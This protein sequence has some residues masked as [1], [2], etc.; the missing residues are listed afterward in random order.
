MVD[1]VDVKLWGKN[2]GVL[3]WD[4]ARGVA[5]FQY[6]NEFI[7][8]GLEISPFAMP[9]N[10]TP[11]SFN[12]NKG[13]CFKG[14]PGLIADSLPDNYG[15]KIIEEWFISQAQPL[16]TITPLDQ[17]CYIGERSMGALEFSPSTQITL[18]NKSTTIDIAQIT[19]L[20]QDILNNRLQFKSKLEDNQETLLDILKI[21]TSAGGAKPKAII[22]YNPNTKEVRSGQVK[23]PQGFEYYILKFDG[24]EEEKKIR[25][26]PLGI[27]RIEYAYYLMSKDCGINMMD[28]FLIEEGQCAHFMT[29]RFDRTEDGEK[30]FVQTLAALGHLDR[31]LPHSYER[32]F[33]IMRGIN[34]SYKEMEQIYRRM[35][36]N[37]MARNH[38]DHTKNH[39]FIMTQKGNWQLAPAYDV[40]Y[41][42]SSISKWTA[43]HQMSINGKRDDFSNNDLLKVAE[44]AEIKKPKNIIEEV[45]QVVSQWNKYAKEAEVA[46]E[47]REEIGRELIPKLP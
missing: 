27:G 33:A 42:Y 21:G 40:M 47:Y 28:S 18:L 45:S 38:D 12:E 22:A 19:A 30:I 25:E 15:T 29:K 43:Q 34:L 2:V 10:K 35:V 4:K 14:L 13:N 37:V 6:T 3:S 32:M 23:A 16:T 24:V 36:F 5:V 31:D 41:S 11:Y 17:L 1:I 46:K 7:T 8:K 26:N 44:N 39:S 20:A 9:L